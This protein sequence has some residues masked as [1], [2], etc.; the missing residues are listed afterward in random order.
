MLF[1]LRSKR[2]RSAVRVV[3]VFLALIMLSGLVL[4]GVGTGNNNGGLLNAFT[5]NGSGSGG[6]QFANQAVNRAIKATKKD[7][8]AAN[9]SALLQAR[10]SDANSGSNYDATTDTFTASGKKQL[11][12]GADAW[13]RYLKATG[14]KPGAQNSTLAAELYQDLSQWSNASSAWEYAAQA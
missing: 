14:D 7:P 5:N 12:A 6:D 2:R 11:Q 10:W 8:S 13:Q 4:V 1:D 9:W 3:Y